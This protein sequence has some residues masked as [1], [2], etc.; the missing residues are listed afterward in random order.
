MLSS[1]LIALKIGM[2]N[3]SKNHIQF[4][5]V[6]HIQPVWEVWFGFYQFTHV[7]IFVPT[8]T[9]FDEVPWSQT[10]HIKMHHQWMQLDDACLHTCKYVYL[11]YATGDV[12]KILLLCIKCYQATK[13]DKL[14]H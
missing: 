5:C 10:V 11:T 4:M 9:Q 6:G 3:R 13:M 14:H 7:I 12:K 1:S 2:K 8:G